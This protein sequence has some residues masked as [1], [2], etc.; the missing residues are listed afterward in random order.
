MVQITALCS[1]RCDS[2]RDHLEFPTSADFWCRTGDWAVE[3]PTS[4]DFLARYPL[5]STG[6]ISVQP[7]SD[8]RWRMQ[9]PL[10]LVW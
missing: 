6:I 9:V 3:S 2:P 5:G 8:P 4:A 10:A 1:A 7:S